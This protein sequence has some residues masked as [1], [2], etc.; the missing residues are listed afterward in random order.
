MI[1]TYKEGQV[2]PYAAVM[3]HINTAEYVLRRTNPTIVSDIPEEL[4]AKWP[5]DLAVDLERLREIEEA[6]RQ[7]QANRQLACEMGMD[8]QPVGMTEMTN[9]ED[10]IQQPGL[11][12]MFG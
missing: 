2:L 6:N 5:A 11:R 7:H 3:Y 10:F 4:V 1:N 12:S 9:L 8:D